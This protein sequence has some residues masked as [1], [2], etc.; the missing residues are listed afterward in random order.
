MRSEFNQSSAQNLTEAQYLAEVLRGAVAGKA[1]ALYD[2]EVASFGTAFAS[3]PWAERQAVI[4]QLN[5][6]I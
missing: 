3:K 4:A 2:Q 6:Q 5:A 1:K